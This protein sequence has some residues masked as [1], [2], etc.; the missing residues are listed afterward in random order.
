MIEGG[1]VLVSGAPAARP[2]RLVDSSEPVEVLG[3]PPRFVS[4]GGE[5]LEAAL[6]AFG[7]RVT[8]RRALDA[9]ASTGGFTDCL[10]QRGAISVVALDVGRAQL[11]ERLRSDPRVVVMERTDVRSASPATLGKPFEIVVADLSFISLR[12]VAS[13]LVGE[14]A[15]V[16]ADVVVLVKPQFEAGREA[17]SK[18]RGVIRDPVV[19]AQ[20]LRD[21]SSSFAGARAA[22]MGAMPSPITGAEG[23]VEFFLHALA[24][25]GSGHGLD[26]AEIDACV[27][28]A[29][30]L[31]GR[32]R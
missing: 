18:G 17:A 28:A 8:G 21:V 31:H 10:L 22:M 7:V 3:P 13:S 24:H 26:E 9:G 16:D 1:T 25:R 20:A 32:G 29:S 5:K 2:S 15:A 30:E 12:S 14:V 4:R 11:H 27:A 6:E 23:N 19:W